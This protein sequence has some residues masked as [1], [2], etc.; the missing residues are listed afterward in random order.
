MGGSS[1]KTL[2][3]FGLPVLSWG[4]KSTEINI[5]EAIKWMMDE[6]GVADSKIT[7]GN[8][9]KRHVWVHVCIKKRS[10]NIARVPFEI[11]K[12]GGDEPLPNHPA[13]EIF[14][15][16]N[17]YLDS[18][19]LWEGTE[20][21]KLFRGECFWHV[22]RLGNIVTNIFL[23]PPSQMKENT[24]KDG[25]LL[26]WTQR[27][28]GGQEKIY[29]PD[30]II[31][32]KFFNP[33]SNYRGLTPLGA[34]K[35]TIETDDDARRFNRSVLKNGSPPGGVLE[36]DGDTTAEQ[37]KRMRVEWEENHKGGDAAGKIG[38]LWGGMHYKYL[39][40]TQADAAFIEQRKM[41]QEEVHAVYETPMALTSETAGNTNRANFREIKQGW[42][43]EV[44]I[45]EGMG[46][47][48]NLKTNF[49]DKIYPG[50]EGRF[51][52]SV[53]PE[54]QVDMK[55]MTEVA[56]KLN[57]MG[58]TPD[59][60]NE[61]LKLGFPDD[62]F[63]RKTWYKPFSLQP[64]DQEPG[65]S[66]EPAEDDSEK[67]QRWLNDIKALESKKAKSEYIKKYMH[68]KAFIDKTEPIERAYKS[69]LSRWFLE[70][71]K[72]ILQNLFGQMKDIEDAHIEL[73]NQTEQNKKLTEVSTPYFEE[74]LIKGGTLALDEIGIES[75]YE[76]VSE[77]S[78]TFLNEKIIKV[79]QITDT[80]KEELREAL[81]KGLDEGMTNAEIADVVRHKLNIASGRSELI[82]RT[83]INGAANGGRFLAYKENGI[84]RHSWVHSF[85]R[86]REAHSFSQT[87]KV[88]EE[89]QNGLKHPGD[90][91]G[92][93]STAKNLCNC[94]CTTAAEL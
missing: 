46:F 78:I 6:L 13:A 22:E 36:T 26:G 54:L 93:Q 90:Q 16:V 51:N 48:K 50:Y 59:E 35:F 37:R 41:G 84:E 67:M 64:V 57:K 38:I 7:E 9:Y 71:R 62:K 79:T 18:A 52:Y 63:W 77:E 55:A 31:Q 82:A 39:Q 12:V 83:E 10:A 23:L 81:Q 29:T 1:E 68:W 72:E 92:S 60:I 76:L 85:D 42:W 14:N 58:F 49:F 70:L 32:F 69:K 25:E 2:S 20:T 21:Y 17:P 74:A 27:L 73:F 33:Y 87:V 56:E 24:D 3:V 30:E 45:P 28:P 34:L 65:P 5:N 61:R 43:T 88:G 94:R 19:Q 53:I 91:T 4:K 89:F 44:L 15:T 86:V 8:A 80:V 11:F 75:A 66:A 47:E 40:I